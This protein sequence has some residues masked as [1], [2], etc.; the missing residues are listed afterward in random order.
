MITASLV[1][2]RLIQ[3]GLNTTEA[4]SVYGIINAMAMPIIML[5]ST[6]ISALCVTLLPRLASINASGKTEALKSRIKKVLIFAGILCGIC[7]LVLSLT[8]TFIGE[9]LYSNT[10]AG[11][12]IRYLS[13]CCIF[14]GINQLCSTVLTS[15][16][17]E[18]KTFK[19]HIT[20]SVCMLVGS[21]IF[22]G[23][24]G[25]NGY[26]TSIILQGATGTALF[27]YS[28]VNCVKKLLPKHEN[29]CIVS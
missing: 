21:F 4:F 27:L 5:P 28:T 8:A 2:L 24:W 7:S 6:L 10:Q 3:N 14:V 25:A 17:H 16:G 13:P 11:L 1:P 20:T 26:A 9:A 15:I 22:T 29:K 23:I 19:I 18:F 12:F